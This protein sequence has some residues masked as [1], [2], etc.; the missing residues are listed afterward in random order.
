[1]SIHAQPNPEAQEALAIQRRNS[2]VSSIIIALLLCTLI[3]IILYVI[4]F[5]IN[6]KNNEVTIARTTT[7]DTAPP[8]TEPVMNDQVVSNPAAP[9]TNM[10]SLPRAL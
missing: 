6:L 10:A 2:T 5:K 9:A 3:G 1:M 4:A 7:S 8:L